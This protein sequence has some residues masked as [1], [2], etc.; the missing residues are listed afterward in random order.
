MLTVLAHSSCSLARATASFG[1]LLISPAG[2]FEKISYLFCRQITCSVLQITSCNLVMFITKTFRHQICLILRTCEYSVMLI[3][4]RILCLRILYRIFDYS[5][6]P[7]L[8]GI[9]CYLLLK[10]CKQAKI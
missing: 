7:Y 8:K 9:D 6:E 1:D 4:I 2:F 3:T 5:F 10:F